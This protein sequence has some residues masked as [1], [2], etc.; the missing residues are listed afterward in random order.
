LSAALG[1][2]QLF[3]DVDDDPGEGK[4]VPPAGAVAF[5]T[6]VTWEA[7]LGGAVKLIVDKPRDAQ[8]GDRMIATLALSAR[9]T[10]VYYPAEPTGVWKQFDATTSVCPEGGR[11]Y[12]RYWTRVFTENEPVQYDFGAPSSFVTASLVIV[13]FSGITPERFEARVT[14]LVDLP[15]GPLVAPS[16]DAS[17]PSLLLAV[18]T[19]RTGANGGKWAPIDGLNTRQAIGGVAVFDALVGGGPTGDRTATVTS[20]VPICGAT[21]F[22][23]S[24]PLP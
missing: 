18:F 3:L 19:N 6:P 16:V 10:I 23:M 2:C 1:G 24:L 21:A 22:A 7:Y 13:A 11:Q 14:K 8:P 15:A 9:D 17:G 20:P 12:V 5:R 4:K